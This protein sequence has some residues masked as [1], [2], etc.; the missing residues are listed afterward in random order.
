MYILSVDTLSK[1]KILINADSV[2]FFLE[3]ILYRLSTIYIC[4]ELYHL[5]FGFFYT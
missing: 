1:N 4:N 5:Q 2:F 3:K